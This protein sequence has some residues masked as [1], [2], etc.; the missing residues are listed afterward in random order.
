MTGHESTLSERADRV[1]SEAGQWLGQGGKIEPAYI[2]Q[3]VRLGE[4]RFAR[5]II[6]RVDQ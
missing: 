5:K 4:A 1:R 3:F 6:G 2:G